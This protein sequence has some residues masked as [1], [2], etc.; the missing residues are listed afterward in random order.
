M[1]DII[2]EINNA[3]RSFLVEE[4]QSIESLNVIKNKILEQLNEIA[5]KIKK[6][7]T[8]IYA[9]DSLRT[10]KIL[11]NKV[12][13][14]KEQILRFYI[15]QKKEYELNSGEISKKIKEYSRSLYLLNLI[16]NDEEIDFFSQS[17]LEETDKCLKGALYECFGTQCYI[18]GI[19]D[20]IEKK[21]TGR[22]GNNSFGMQNDCGIACVTQIIILSG[23]KVSENDVVRVAIG[24]GLCNL[25]SNSMRNNGATSVYNR[26]ALLKRFNIDSIIKQVDYRQLA[27]YIEKGFGVIVSVDSGILWNRESDLGI[28]HAIVLYGTVHRASDGV[29]IGFVACDTGSGNMQKF[30]TCEDFLRMTNIDRGANITLRAIRG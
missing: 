17:E 15:S 8:S 1:Q 11:C 3:I 12:A 23:K 22:Q 5:Y 29:L 14:A 26:A 6:E 2:N 18:F 13:K 4:K 21:F 24:E 30:L 16:K 27:S 7:Q 10:I 19:E 9:K 20:N 28:G 25:M